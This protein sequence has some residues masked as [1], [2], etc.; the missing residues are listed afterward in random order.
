[1]NWE[2]V[3]NLVNNGLN[4]IFYEFDQTNYVYRIGQIS[5]NSGGLYFYNEGG[6]VLLGQN[7]LSGQ[8]TYVGAGENYWLSV[9]KTANGK[10]KIIIPV[11]SS[12]M[13]QRIASVA[14]W[15]TVANLINNGLDK[16]V[17]EF[18]QARYV[19]RVGRTSGNNNG[20]LDF[21]NEAG[22]VNLGSNNITSN[23]AGEDYWLS[24]P[25]TANGK[26]K[27]IP[28]INS[29]VRIQ[30]MS[31]ISNANPA[32]TLNSPVANTTLHE[33]STLTLSGNTTDTDVDN[34]VTIKYQIDSGTVRNLHS[35]VSDGTTAIN[36]SKALTYKEGMLYDSTTAVT[37]VLDKDTPHTVS[38]WAEDDKGGKSSVITRTFFIVPNRP[39]SITINP[40]G[41]QSDL[42]NSNVINVSGAVTDADNNEITVKFSI[43]GGEEQQVYVGPPSNFAFNILLAD[44]KFGANT[45]IARATDTYN[46]SS[47]KTL[48]INKTH[49]AV[50]VNKAVARYAIQ[51]PTGNAKS[52]LLWITR[53]LGNI[54]ITAEVSMTNGAETENYVELSKT[55]SAVVNGLK[56]DEFAFQGTTEK[57]KIILKITYDRTDATVVDTIK[58]ISGVLF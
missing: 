5:G 8:N 35:G 12:V 36:F 10:V 14:A 9:P 7:Y 19:Y 34:V 1:M 15:E 17:Y 46:T 20:S 29:S 21:Y 37:S 54:G 3:I 16:N 23:I 27:I 13:I 33:N 40:I 25:K 41:T 56:E 45:V 11:N 57:E 24:V 53:T 28:P 58:Q 22:S 32:I 52:I 51:A 39:P 38:I 43:N 18:D 42:I 49:N 6:A 55:N 48:T 47:T 2:T 50:P 4:N 30:R 26:V 31:I 44:L